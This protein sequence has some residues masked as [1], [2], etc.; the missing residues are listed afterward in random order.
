MKPDAEM[1]K[2]VGVS[3]L[4]FIEPLQEFMQLRIQSQKFQDTYQDFQ[5][6]TEL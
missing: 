5:D 2:T 3:P 6:N 4:S 1:Q